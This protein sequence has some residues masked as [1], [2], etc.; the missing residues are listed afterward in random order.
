MRLGALFALGKK[1]TESDRT[2]VIFRSHEGKIAG[3]RS[4]DGEGDM[5]A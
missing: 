5:E 1:P 3:R 2:C 4:T